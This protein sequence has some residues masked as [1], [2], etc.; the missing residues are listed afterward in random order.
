MFEKAPDLKISAAILLRAAMLKDL[1]NYRIARLMVDQK[2]EVELNDALME[3]AIRWLDLHTVALF[4]SLLPGFEIS[5][6]IVQAAG[7]N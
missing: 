6:S 1:V 4:A 3:M 5:R 7:S 2:R